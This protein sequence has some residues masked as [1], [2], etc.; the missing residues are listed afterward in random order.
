MRR[1]EYGS[2]V[3]VLEVA[4]DESWLAAFGVLPQSECATGDDFVRE[5]TIPVGDAEEVQITWDV[6]DPSVRVR[7]RRSAVVV[8]DLFRELATRLTVMSHG[9]VKEVVV[10]YGIAGV[11]G[12]SR[13][14]IAP[15]VLIVD[16]VLR[17]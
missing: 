5:L 3:P 6:T 14:Q 10:E 8:C 15:S 12:R 2:G 11:A 7:H 1:R 16:E 9:P 13:I 4:D 17:A